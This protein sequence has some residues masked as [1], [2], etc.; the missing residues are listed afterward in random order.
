MSLNQG[1]QSRLDFAERVRENQR[2]LRQ[3]L[4]SQ[5]DFI[6]CGQVPPDQ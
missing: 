6:V 1:K 5:Y 3:G 4:R 2:K